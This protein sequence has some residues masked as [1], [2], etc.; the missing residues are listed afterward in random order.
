MKWTLLSLALFP[1]CVI[2]QHAGNIQPTYRDALRLVALH[3]AYKLSNDSARAIIRGDMIKIAERYMRIEHPSQADQNTLLSGLN[4]FP[5][6]SSPGPQKWNSVGPDLSGQNPERGPVSAQS[7]GWQASAINGLSSFMAGRFR[8][9]VIHYG[10]ENVFEKILNE[11]RAL[12]RILFPITLSE[13]D[14]LKKGNAYYSADLVFLRRVIQEDLRHLPVRM[15]D[16]TQILFPKVSANS[17]DNDMLQIGSAIY[18]TAAKGVSLPELINQ[19]SYKKYKEHDVQ[20]QMNLINLYSEALRDTA[21]SDRLWADLTTLQGALTREVNVRNVF[22]GLLYEQIRLLGY[23]ISQMEEIRETLSLFAHLNATDQYIKARS[24][25]L[26]LQEGS[27]VIQ[28]IGI[29]ITDYFLTVNKEKL[30]HIIQAQSLQ[31]ISKLLG[32]IAPFQENDYQRGILSLIKEFG[33]YLPVDI[34]S[35]GRRSLIFAVQLAD[36]KDEEDLEALLQ[37]YALPIGGSSIKRS[38]SFNISLNGYVGLTGGREWAYGS[39]GPQTK[40]NVGLSAPIG[41]SATF[42]SNWTLFASI[43]DLGSIVNVRINNDT[44]AFADLRFEHFLTPGVGLY[45]NMNKSPVTLAAHYSY[46][47][48]LRTIAYQ[49]AG[50]KVTESGV[51]VSRLNFSVLI[52]IP[53][54]TF[55][56]KIRTNDLYSVNRKRRMKSPRR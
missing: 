15:A 44:T 48:N 22:F 43:I 41:I 14:K 40:W 39:L 35:G 34:G 5:E 38:S 9:E 53:F 55:H 7:L 25:R 4:I 10:L 6:A 27:L 32:V 21:G 13:I 24:N 42:W 20:I 8:Q 17:F 26:T 16:S 30:P 28:Q 31:F 46:I 36:T 45:F 52:D 19:L 3:E 50:A 37:A 18:Q 33:D 1:L 54:F 2:A 56:N 29:A 51:S 23:Q 49:Q 11:D 12:Y 47:P